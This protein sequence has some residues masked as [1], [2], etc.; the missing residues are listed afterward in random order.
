MKYISKSK[1]DTKKLAK[2]IAI[3]L[4]G[5]EIIGLVGDLGAG[6]TTFIQYLAKA[7]GVKNTVNSPTFNIMKIYKIK[8][9]APL[10]PYR[11]PIGRSSKGVRYFVHIDAYRLNSASELSAIGAEE[12][13]NESNA[14]TVIEW[15]YKIKSILP[16]NAMI[17]KICAKKENERMFEICSK[18]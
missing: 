3:Q 4:K 14:I 11:R 5:G 6:K 9:Q 15:A 12:Y 2:K 1:S 16:K 10:R 18:P 13:F 8:S 17:I 7:M